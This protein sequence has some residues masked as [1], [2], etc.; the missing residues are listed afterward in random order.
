MTGDTTVEVVSSDATRTYANGKG[1]LYLCGTPIGNL[2]DISLRALR[3]LRECDLIAAEDTRRTRKLLKHYGIK[4][5]VVSCHSHNEGKRIPELLSRL[6]SGEVVSLVSDAGMPGISDPGWRLV[7]AAI[8]AGI[9]VVPVPGPSAAILAL[10]SSG[11]PPQRFVFE[12]FL[13]STRRRRLQKLRELVDESR[14]IVFFESPRRLLD[15][16]SDIEASLGRR[17]VAVAR[18]ITKRFEEVL[19]GYV[20]EVKDRLAERNLKGEITLVVEGKGTEEVDEAVKGLS[21]EPIEIRSAVREEMQKGA[22]RM[23]AIKAVA[24]RF[25][26]PKSKVYAVIVGRDQRKESGDE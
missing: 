7:R 12:G 20:D 25:D 18:E 11:L 3:V 21:P 26:I 16:L 15:T 8:E 17:R 24:K 19:R 9:D 6:K 13:P 5:P 4:T 10:V 1:L 23:E 22:T 14:T 2:E